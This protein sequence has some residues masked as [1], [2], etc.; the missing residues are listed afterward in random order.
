M[1]SKAVLLLAFGGADSP[2]N[3]EPFV[4][5]VL[6][7]RPVTPDLIER[8]KER[9]ALIGGKSPL[10]EITT[11]QAKAI[12][13]LL[14]K[15][16]LDFKVY[17]GM[18]YWHP[19]IKDTLK[20][21]KDDGVTDA[22]TLI[23]A[24]FTS[25]VAAGGYL[26]D[27]EEAKKLIENPPRLEF[28]L[29]W[30][31][32]PQFIDII[33]EKMQEAMSGLERKDALVIFSC[34]SLPMALLEG[35]A[36]EMKIQQ[37]AGEI[38]RKAPVDYRIAYQ[39]KGSGP[40]DWLGPATEDVIAQAKIAGKESVVVVPLGFAA[41]HVETLYD[42]DILFKETAESLGLIFKRSASLNTAPKFMELIAGLI[43]KNS[44]VN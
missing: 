24:P 7:G 5:N 20:R 16:G 19:F 41:D 11:A 44:G 40:R 22:V 10:L 28:I 43:K 1:G 25:K 38:A 36:Y 35:D 39:S 29:D 6:K 3:V 32:R 18:R 37:T 2:E 9:Y 4:K 27:I 42:I 21:M 26:A 33:I 12:E 30:H 23:M 34:H 15:A 31:V 8:A 17:I 14:K 13:G